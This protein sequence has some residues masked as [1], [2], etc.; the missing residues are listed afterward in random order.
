MTT[1]TMPTA[2]T[3][4]AL[5]CRRAS[6]NT[7]AAWRGTAGSAALLVAAFV[8]PGCDPDPNPSLGGYAGIEDPTIRARREAEVAKLPPLALQGPSVP[9]APVAQIS[10]AQVAAMPADQFWGATRAATSDAQLTRLVRWGAKRRLHDTVWNAMWGRIT[11]PGAPGHEDAPALLVEAARLATAIESATSDR[12]YATRVREYARAHDGDAR[13]RSW[14]QAR[15]AEARTAWERDRKPDVA[16]ARLA[17]AKSAATKLKMTA[18]LAAI[19]QLER[20][21]PE[22]KK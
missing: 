12:S 11:T 8:W 17:A 9:S 5:A 6:P 18:E 21:L 1:P 19:A 15:L 3:P 22:P 7:R 2:L 13:K 14:V 20:A 4:D 10:R 16:R